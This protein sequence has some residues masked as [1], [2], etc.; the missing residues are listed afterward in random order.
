[1]DRPSFKRKGDFG[2]DS[3]RKSAKS[4]GDDSA[5]PGKPKTKMSFAERM[6][7]KM[8]Y[9][10]GEGLGKSGDGIL[11]PIEVKL[12]PQGVGVGA[13]KEKTAQAKAEARRQA[14]RRGE[15][16]EDSSEEERKAEKRR[17]NIAK[18]ASTGSGTSTPGG[19]VRQKVKYKTATDIE[20]A[21][22]GL[23]VPAVLKSLIDATGKETRLLTSTAGLLTPLGGVV[24][25]ETS[26]EK[27]AKRARLDLEA[28]ADSWNH[29]TEAMKTLEFQ[30]DQLQREMDTIETEIRK[31][32]GI[33]AA[34][35]QLKRVDLNKA[36]TSDEAKLSW[37]EVVSQLETIQFEYR[38]EIH[39][40]DL[41]S[42][43]VAII[44]PLFKQEMLDWDPLENP[45]HMVTYLQR[46]RTILG[47][48]K[49]ALVSRVG[50]DDFDRPRK[51]KYTTP[52]ETMIYT[53]WLPKVRTTIINDWDP[54]MPTALLALVEAWRDILPEF[55]YNNMLNQ[56][57]VQKLS[58]AVRNW[59]PRTSLKKKHSAPLPHI[60]LFPWLPYLSEHHTDPKG[61]SGLLTDVKR[62]FRVALDTWDLSRGVMPG[63]EHWREVLRGELDSALIRHLLPRLASLL[64]LDFEVNPA[65][66]G[67]QP[68]EQV[69][70]WKSFFKPSVMG[71]LLVAEFFPKWLAILHSWL[72]ADPNYEEVGQWF[73]WWKGVFSEDINNARSVAQMWEKGLEMINQALDLGDRART[74]L[75]LPKAPTHRPVA[76][77][78]PSRAE[79]GAKAVRSAKKKEIFE[80]TTFK[81]VVEAWCGE[82]N[83][84]LIPLREAH[85]VTGLPLFRITASATGR[86]GVVVYMKGDVIYAQNKKDK[87]LWQPVG[88][89]EGLVARAEGK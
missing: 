4:D 46:L 39:S 44:H 43:A 15:E 49:D 45:M 81:D 21:A 10:E 11:N 26:A 51:K 55:V 29:L 78:T 17:K 30:E 84:L 34:V 37:E 58:A 68:L 47:I 24:P 54:Q 83:L 16:Y 76:P 5:R 82:Q 88:L 85:Q 67:I 80:E 70:A 32:Q 3:S 7:A 73:T 74:D 9:K 57:V 2:Q 22:E 62:K 33:T 20:A 36:R 48:N 8:G 86:G 38:D 42:V 89:E 56:L 75:P 19:Y 59:N 18:A 66:Q 31:A 14:E 50:L 64:R 65:D 53:L 12:R 61:S 1:M 77:D 13:V 41:T 28:Y 71:E 23:H 40:F 60:W 25:A 6:M 27:I 35:T 69:L 52:Y 87:T 63:L 79:A 72:T